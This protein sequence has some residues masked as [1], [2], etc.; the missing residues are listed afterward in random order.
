LDYIKFLVSEKKL[1]KY[2]S[3]ILGNVGPFG[4]KIFFN[5]LLET[6]DQFIFES[7]GM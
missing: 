6:H 3:P 1:L 2:F 5:I 4:K 7:K